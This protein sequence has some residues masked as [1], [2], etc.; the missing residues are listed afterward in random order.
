MYNKEDTASRFFT[1]SDEKQTKIV[2]ELHSLWWSRFYEYIWASKFIEKDDIV[3]DSA[4]G[5]C[6]PFKFYLTDLCKQVYAC[7]ND[8]RIV[9]KEAILTDVKLSL[10][11][12]I[13]DGFD[14]N[15]LTKPIYTYCDIAETPYEDKQFDKICCVSVVEHLE[16]E[17]QKD[18]IKEYSRVIKDGGLLIITLDYPNAN[19]EDILKIAKENGFELFGDID[20]NIPNNA[21]SCNYWDHTLY[22]FR[23]VLKKKEITKS[24]GR[25]KKN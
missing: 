24:K 25:P 13:L 5:I 21:L 15:Y 8:I 20:L 12:D 2:W 22:C 10:G 1:T 19:P 18:T 23:M 3:L 17:K 4:S 9:D 14:K 11:Q 6:H 16:V 7:D